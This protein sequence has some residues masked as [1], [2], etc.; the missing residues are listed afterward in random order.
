MGTRHL[1]A[2]VHEGE[3]KVAQYGQWD[4]YPSGQGAGVLNFLQEKMDRALFEE[5]LKNVSF[6]TQEEL[7]QRWVDA[8]ADPG[9]SFVTLQVA[10]TM[11]A[12]YPENSRD[13]GSDIL[14]II[15]D[16]DRPIKIVNSL[17]FAGDSVFCEWGYV[18]DLDKNTFEV[19]KGFNEIPLTESDRFYGI[20]SS[21]DNHHAI[22]LL[23]S[24]DLNNLPT[25]EAFI[26]ELDTLREAIA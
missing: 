4:G 12:R 20:P 3:Y 18:V 19:Y 25:E 17:D 7:T 6:I 15:Q 2:V 1:I 10:S 9:S 24:F 23:K 22:R 26:E 11:Q 16:A 21:N 14:A 8:G 5:K 13:T